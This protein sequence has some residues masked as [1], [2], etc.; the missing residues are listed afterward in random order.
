[1]PSE[2]SSSLSPLERVLDALL[3]S[4]VLTSPSLPPPHPECTHGEVDQWRCFAGGHAAAQA[5]PA[6]PSDGRQ[7]AIHHLIVYRDF[8]T[9]YG[10]R[11]RRKGHAFAAAAIRTCACPCVSQNQTL[12]KLPVRETA[13]HFRG[14]SCSL[15]TCFCISGTS[16]VG[17]RLLSGKSSIE[18]HRQSSICR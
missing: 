15:E 16:V 6:P 4:Y 8:A 10:A 3:P 12:A 13:S 2:F 17:L 11:S 7:P 18:R 14:D 5:D 9:G 1:M